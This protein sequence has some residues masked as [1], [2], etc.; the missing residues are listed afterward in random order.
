MKNIINFLFSD[1]V[2][3]I[4]LILGAM[5]KIDKHHYATAFILTVLAGIVFYNLKTKNNNYE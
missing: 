1:K 3:F 5:Y 2:Y 4:F